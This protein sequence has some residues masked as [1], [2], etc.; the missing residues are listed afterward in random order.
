[1]NDSK[2]Q[3]FE[4]TKSVIFQAESVRIQPCLAVVM[5]KCLNCQLYSIFRT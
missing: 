1:M 3:N 5:K 4:L 2:D